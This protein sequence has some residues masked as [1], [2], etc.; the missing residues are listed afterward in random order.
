MKKEILRL[1]LGFLLI[2]L[3]LNT[4]NALT[5]SIGNSETIISAKVGDIIIK[6]ILVKNVND[7]LIIVN[8]EVIQGSDIYLLDNEG[9]YFLLYPDEEIKLK[10]LMKVLEIGETENKIKI[11][12]F[13]AEGEDANVSLVAEVIVNGEE[14][15]IE[16]VKERVSVL[17]SWRQALENT[18]SDIL[19]S[20]VSLVTKTNNHEARLSNLD[21][22]NITLNYFKYLSS[23]DRKNMLCGYAED[24]HLT[25]VEDLG[26]VCDIIYKQTSRGERA[27]CR[28]KN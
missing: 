8:A 5:G 11:N 24:N 12:F 10:Y 28:C 3:L 16:K 27:S 6:D 25:H 23:S 18:I 14:S 13:A 21:G 19:A 2:I 9:I 15:E 17:E 1:I 26:L 20:I 7:I 22:G 4:I